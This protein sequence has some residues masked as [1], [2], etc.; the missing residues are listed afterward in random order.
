LHALHLSKPP[1]FGLLLA[2]VVVVAGSALR[3]ATASATLVATGSGVGIAIPRRLSASSEAGVVAALG[4]V[5]SAS[6]QVVVTWAE[7]DEQ[8][9]AD[10]MRAASF[11]VIL[12]PDMVMAVKVNGVFVWLLVVGSSK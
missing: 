12:L 1:A 7:T 10:W 8:T 9:S 4:L 5:M 3:A 6:V 11:W 2:R